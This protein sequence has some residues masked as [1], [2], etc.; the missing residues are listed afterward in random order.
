MGGRDLA[1]GWGVVGGGWNGSLGTES[2][3]LVQLASRSATCPDL[4]G[5]HLSNSSLQVLGYFLIFKN[6]PHIHIHKINKKKN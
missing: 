1:S 4:C 5:Q 3:V 2:R 6:Y